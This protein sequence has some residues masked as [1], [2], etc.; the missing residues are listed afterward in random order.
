MNQKSL[1]DLKK[2]DVESKS[3]WHILHGIAAYPAVVS[4]YDLGV[5][6]LLESNRYSFGDFCEKLKLQKRAAEALLG[7]LVSLHLVEKKDELYELCF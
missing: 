7:F 2:P 5:F 1:E 3:I 4:A 6:E